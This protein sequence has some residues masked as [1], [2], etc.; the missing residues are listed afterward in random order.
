MIKKLI[1]LFLALA[2]IF[3]IVPMRGDSP[4]DEG[5]EIPI[6]KVDDNRIIRGLTE[7]Q[8]SAW[9]NS[10]LMCIQTHASTNLGQIEMTVTNLTTGETWYDIFNSAI[11]PHLL[12]ISGAPGLYEITYLTSFGDLYEG[13]FTIE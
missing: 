11:S 6:R 2:A 1:S 8:L 3:C 13:T 12:P 7:V 10:V 9:Y 5:R 4:P